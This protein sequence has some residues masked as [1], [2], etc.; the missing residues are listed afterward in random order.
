MFFK[1]LIP[2]HLRCRS[3]QSN[4]PTP[5]HPFFV[6][7]HH[8][9]CF[10]RQLY[11]PFPN[12]PTLLQLWTE[13]I[14]EQLKTVDSRLKDGFDLSSLAYISS[15]YSCGAVVRACKATLSARRLSQVLA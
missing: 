15:G 5:N 10:E 3:H 14:T 12:Y 11:I 9:Q 4:T 8:R 13:V 2:W 7:E 1:N 6:F